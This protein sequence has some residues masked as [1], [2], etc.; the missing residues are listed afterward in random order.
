MRKLLS[1]VGIVLVLIGTIWAVWSVLK[2][3]STEVAKAGYLD[4]SEKHFRDQKKHVIIGLVISSVGSA[5]QI[6]GVLI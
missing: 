1:V 5:M 3:N 2:T 4:S 6:F